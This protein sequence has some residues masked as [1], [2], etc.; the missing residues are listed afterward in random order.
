M[1]VVSNVVGGYIL[2]GQYMVHYTC[3]SFAYYVIAA[4]LEDNN[5]RFIISFYFKF[6]GHGHHVFCIS[7]D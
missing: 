7:R 1:Y 2:G 3:R 6:H 4:M 5:K